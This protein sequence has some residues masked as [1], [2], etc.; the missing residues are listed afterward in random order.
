MF[1]VKCIKAGRGRRG[2]CPNGLG[3]SRVVTK[4]RDDVPVQV[5]RQIA[6]T[7]DIHFLRPQRLPQ[8]GLQREYRVHKYLTIRR[9]EI[10]EFPDML[11]PDNAAETGIGGTISTAHPYHAPFFA[12]GNHFAAVAIT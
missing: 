5:R 3:E 12:A 11:V 8:R 6:E 1:V 4:S 9:R 10:G 2:Y 7:G